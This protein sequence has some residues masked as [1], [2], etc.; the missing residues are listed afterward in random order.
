[1]SLKLKYEDYSKRQENFRFY[2][3]SL[4]STF[5]KRYKNI[6]SHLALKFEYFPKILKRENSKS[7]KS[8]GNHQKS[9][10]DKENAP[11]DK[12]EE[13][14]SSFLL[15][16]SMS[17]NHILS[18]N[19]SPSHKSVSSAK[20][21]Q[22]NLQTDLLKEQTKKSSGKI[23]L[24]PETN[25]NLSKN[26]SNKV[27]VESKRSEE[28]TNTEP[29]IS[30]ENVE[31]AEKTNVVEETEPIPEMD[32]EQKE[33]EVELKNGKND[34]EAVANR[35]TE[36]QNIAQPNVEPINEQTKSDE[37][38]NMVA[39]DLAAKSICQKEA[40]TLPPTKS[41]SF[42]RRKQTAKDNLETLIGARLGN[43]MAFSSAKKMPFKKSPE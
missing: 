27:I 7:A 2:K 16:K 37:Q 8:T 10:S 33:S 18:K 38:K 34:S 21:F 3:F 12:L 39:A 36:N 23:D 14:K 40:E 26:G 9:H 15:E 42:R 24:K 20:D 30:I 31:T 28:T 22:K 17:T 29:E 19:S 43:E 4:A 25:D 5:S 32:V 1:G 35:A 6:E 41:W 13:K 11:L